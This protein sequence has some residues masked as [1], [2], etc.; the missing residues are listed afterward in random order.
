[1][2]NELRPQESQ[3]LRPIGVQPLPTTPLRVKLS[4]ET[5]HL[6][7]CHANEVS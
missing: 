3:R 6:K 2:L 7:S 4:Q 1:M 5:P